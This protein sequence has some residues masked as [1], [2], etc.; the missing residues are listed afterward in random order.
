MPDIF[1]EVAED[2]RAER[3]RKFLIKYAGVFIAAA[4]L[5]L[6]GIGGWK[7]WQWHQHRQEVR[8]ATQYLT[9]TG[10]IAQAGSGLTKDGEIA[11]AKS[12]VDFAATAPRGY[13]TLARFRA[14]ALYSAAGDTKPAEAL[15]N[16]IGASNGS[17]G[18]LM[19][20]LANLLWAQHA[21]GIVPD[22]AVMARLQPLMAPSSPWH[23]LA[24]M[25]AA[26]LDMQS[27]KTAEAK[28][29]LER[30]SA[31]P[32]SPANLRNLAQGLIAKLNG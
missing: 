11:D 18:P 17:A 12:L 2:L 4:V 19:Q 6:L 16:Q 15:W 32:T 9:L 27:G 28:S 10:R 5:V 23:D 21:M 3:T 20:G 29:L 8:A 22:A 24:Q 30:V 25:N 7:T 13:A 31:D 1:D 26:V 14:A